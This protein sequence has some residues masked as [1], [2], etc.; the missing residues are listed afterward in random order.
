MEEKNYKKN[1]PIRVVIIIV[2]LL[3]MILSI[4][5]IGYL[6]FTNWL[7]SANQ[8]T[9]SIA[10]ET[11]KSIYNEIY[12]FLQVP[13]QINEVNSK[14]ISNGILDLSDVNLRDKFFAGA[15]SSYTSEI[16]S[17]SYGVA[18]G[19]YYGA[20]R[21]NNGVVEIMRNNAGTGGNS[22]YYS[23]ND[24]MTSRNL[25]FQAGQFD[26]RTRAWYQAAVEAGESTFSP[27]YKHF[28]M[29]D[30]TV[31]AAW[32]IYSN[33]GELKG[34]LGVHMLL[35]D[36]GSY[37]QD[38]VSKYNGFA[39]IIEK[40]SGDLIANSMDLDNFTV[41]QD[42]T[43]K[44]H[45]IDEISNIRQAYEQYR[46]NR[47]PDFLYKGENENLFINVH[48]VHLAYLDWVVI[49][50]IPEELLVSKVKKSIH[51]TILLV[52]LALLLSLLIYYAAA[53]R[54]LKPMADLMKVSEA[55]SSGDLSKRV[56]IVRNDE[57]GRISRSLNK[58]ADKM[59]FLINNLEATVKE[60]TEELHRANET[61]AENKNQLRLILDST[62]EGIF[63]ID[64]E[65]K[66]TFCNDS[67]IKI[68][69][70]K[71]EEL[72]GEN[73]HRKI[74][75]SHANGVQFPIEDCKLF[76]SIKQ[77]KKVHSDD[78]KFWRA[79]GTSFEV[80]YHAYP[81]IINNQVIGAVVTFMDITERRK[82]EEDIQYLSC[83]DMLTGLHNRSCFEDHRK[84]VD[85]PENLPLSVIFG[86]LNGLKMTND[87]FGHAAG[88]ALIK[89]S[90]EILRHCCPENA[91]I[92]RIGGDEF[93]ILLPKTN[94]EN[95]E[96]LL[97]RIKSGFLNE[98]VAAIKC[99]ISLGCETKTSEEQ[100]LEEIMTNA[101]NMMYKDK[102]IHRTSVNKEIIETIIETLHSKLPDEKRHSIVVSQLCGDIGN[103]LHLP[104]PS[105]SKLKR[106]G[107]MHDLGKI[108]L[109]ESIF[110]NETWT[111]EEFIKIQQHPIIGY[112]ILNLFDD[113]LDLAEDV[114]GHHER[115]DGKGYP[116]GLKGDEIPLLSR[117]IS[118]AEV[119]ER[120]LNS[121]NGSSDERKKKAIEAI[122]EG[123]SKNFDPVITQL[124]AQLIEEQA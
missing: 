5:S 112:R 46:S 119:Y 98:R 51:L 103:A 99:S 45:N 21:N 79:D 37:L 78:E 83:H 49:S 95:V 58:V 94:K 73:I 82:R 93:I 84:K 74:H 66:C 48:E 109:D 28:V 121:E 31:S 15:L 117:I 124:F 10:D 72:L 2:F 92:A 26:P 56:A 90:S 96:K 76:H 12:A 81:Q 87:I 106:A 75:H 113:T 53:S 18:N 65:G 55:L 11:N 68:L 47:D 105:I 110:F 108:V 115:W 123:S 77:G 1:L 27:V 6:I 63:G 13:L 57:I 88:D 19:E 33:D 120:I 35:S 30:L 24:D 62:A 111:E 7:S 20:R 70:Y 32:P 54:L 69:G 64:L 44:R 102:T 80:E 4:S 89:K 3:A 116:R 60:R 9:E 104:E 40:R 42:G 97:S 59:Q 91:L 101:E 29:D 85:I 52:V 23:V 100:S 39:V 34:V 16:Y 71:E 17:F 8:T 43:L 107:Y 114:Y 25:V 41:L 86:D 61:L 122:K 36:M 50:A 22:W 67:C 118:I 38:M 14:I